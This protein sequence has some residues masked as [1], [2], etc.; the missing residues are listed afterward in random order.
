[1]QASTL[2]GMAALGTHHCCGVFW[3][4]GAKVCE[5]KL[6]ALRKAN[7]TLALTCPQD[8]LLLARGIASEPEQLMHS[9]RQCWLAARPMLLGAPAH[10]PRIWNT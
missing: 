3:V 4:C 1:M 5:E 6:D 7:P 9:L 8:N 10:L 2:R